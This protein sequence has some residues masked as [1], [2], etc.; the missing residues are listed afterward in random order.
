MNSPTILDNHRIIP[1]LLRK[2][3]GDDAVELCSWNGQ[4]AD[5]IGDINF[6]GAGLTVLVSNAGNTWVDGL[7]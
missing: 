4:V 1:A 7:L 2:I 3:N 6:D 5:V